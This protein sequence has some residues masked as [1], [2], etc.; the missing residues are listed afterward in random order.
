VHTRPP[1]PAV[2]AMRTS[3]KAPDFDSASSISSQVIPESGT[4]ARLD[5]Q[6]SKCP[7]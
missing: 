2:P 1:S 4:L 7:A 5:Q 3:K 6:E